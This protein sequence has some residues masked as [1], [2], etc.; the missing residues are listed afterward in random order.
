MLNG[1]FKSGIR[2]ETFVPAEISRTR[3][4][5]RSAIIRR[6]NIGPFIP[7]IIT[8]VNNRCISPL[9]PRDFLSA[10]FGPDAEVGE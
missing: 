4:R 10:S 5:G 3:I 1:F 7:G 8:S 2:E 9:K 6:A